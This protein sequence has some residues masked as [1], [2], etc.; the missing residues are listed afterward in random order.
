MEATSFGFAAFRLKPEIGG[1]RM[2]EVMGF[3]LADNEKGD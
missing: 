2:I 3:S 1:V